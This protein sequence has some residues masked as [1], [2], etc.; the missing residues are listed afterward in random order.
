MEYFEEEQPLDVFE[1]AKQGC[2]EPVL[3]ANECGQLIDVS[4]MIDLQNELNIFH[5]ISF[6]GNAEA[7]NYF[8]L[9]SSSSRL[10]EA[11]LQKDRNGYIPLH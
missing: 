11:L 6:Y 1:Q 3:I 5:L 4:V 7:L 2:F 10:S 8:L 9:K